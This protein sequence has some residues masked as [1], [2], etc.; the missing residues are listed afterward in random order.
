[1]SDEAPY[2]APRETL[3]P[4]LDLVSA[5]Y[6]LIQAWKKT[7]AYIR[8]HNW[9]ADTLAL[10]AA[11]VDLPRFLDGVRQSLGVAEAWA[12]RPLRAV[13]APKSQEWS[14]EAKSQ[15]WRP[16]SKNVRDAKLRPLAHVEL[17]EQ[18]AATAFLLCLADRVEEL[19]GDPEGKI[20]AR[21]GLPGAISYGNRLSCGIADGRLKHRWGSTKLYRSYFSD[22]R[23]FLA[24]PELVAQGFAGESC[25]V[26]QS[27]LRQFYDRV[28]P[29][30]MGRALDG[31]VQPGDDPSFFSALRNLLD[32][33]WDAKD[34]SFVEDY[35]LVNQIPDFASRVVL[36]QGLVA[37]GF[38]A[39]VV[40]LKFDD[41][42]RRSFGSEIAAGVV[43][44]DACRYVDDIRLVL[45]SE[46]KLDLGRLQLQVI[47]WLQSILD[48]S[49]SGLQVAGPEKTTLGYF[50]GEERPITHH[51]SRMERIQRAISGGFDALEGVEI[52]ASIDGLLKA[53]KRFSK[54]RTEGDGW[55]LSPVPDVRDETVARFAAG[56]FRSTY[57]SLRPLLDPDTAVFDRVALLNDVP[58]LSRGARKTRGDLDDD[59]KTF[60]LGLI[61]NWVHDPSN[62]RLLRIGLDLWP[63]VD[64]LDRVLQ[65]LRQYTIPGGRRKAPRLVAW[66]CVAELFRAAAT[67]TGFTDSREKLPDELDLDLY[68]RKLADEGALLMALPA[69]SVPWYVRQQVLLFCAAYHPPSST[70]LRSS[71]NLETKRYRELLLFM[72]GAK[73]P[74][75]ESEKA[76]A[77]MLVRRAFRDREGALNIVAGQLT[78]RMLHHIGESD[79][80]FALELI[81][82]LPH[83]PLGLSAQLRHDLGLTG[84]PETGTWSRLVE[85]TRETPNLLRKERML[86]R[87]AELWIEL[88]TKGQAPEVVAPVDVRVR[89][90]ESDDLADIEATSPRIGR[91]ESIYAPPEW[92]QEPDR[93]RFRLGYLLRFILTGCVDF[94]DSVRAPSWKEHAPIYRQVAGHWQ[95]RKYGFYNGHG[96]FGDHTLP[97]SDWFERFLFALLAWPG[98]THSEATTFVSAGRVQTLAE[99]VL[100]I[101]MLA[102][103]KGRASGVEVLPIATPWPM[104]VPVSRPLRIAVVQT[105]IPDAG[106]FKREDLSLSDPIVRNKHRNHLAAAVAALRRLLDLRATHRGT[107]GQVDLVILPELSV[108]P[109]D[110]ATHLMPF[111]RSH[112][113]IV[114]AGLTYHSP[115]VGAPL[116]NSAV[117]LIPT[118]HPK[119]G[120]QIVR[121]EQCKLHLAEQ[122]KA[123]NVPDPVVAGIRPCQWVVDYPWEAG[124]SAPLRLTASVC[125]DATDL[126]LAADMRERSDVFIVPALNRDV[127]TFDQM[128]LALHYHMYQYVVVA[129]N[130]SF[131]GSNSY[132]PFKEP[133]VR[134]VFHLHGQ[135]QATIAFLEIE[136]IHSLLNRG[137]DSSLPSVDGTPQA[138]RRHWKY[139]PAGW[140]GRHE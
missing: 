126:Q 85:V 140:A 5:D 129:N 28:S 34:R 3:S 83:L 38:F 105:V 125:Y 74:M 130:G 39:N 6:V 44:R 48:G 61:E 21:L 112:R 108:H 81:E 65:L 114:L 137:I 69:P 60:A 49:V 110:V 36:P 111:V 122:E 93:W 120:L 14:V 15:A 51:S 7:S 35:A 134:Q 107:Q 131:G 26:V 27:D 46:T 63:A 90:D 78:P 96:T 100:R 123:F 106:A 94:T 16:T 12:N 75:L 33:Q 104:R 99:V 86:L 70:V 102:R 18:V 136:D 17:R 109:D 13:P 116:I 50:R 118:W 132:A 62:V 43:L 11:A 84:Q 135:P 101:K 37:S 58:G 77:A 25:I 10:D 57:R 22:Y 2:E 98:T 71:R 66:Y 24:R 55:A 128:A 52:L 76:T 29:S 82:A 9:F 56:R 32:W 1:M 117:W 103:L 133:H 127:N 97:I 41:E 87:F 53:Q 121:R 91:D 67:E 80:A 64:V 139:P 95:R 8:A 119:G 4:Q 92:C 73:T 113:T 23:T 20:T 30:S 47:E 72:M 124:G 88:E 138:D 31:L 42:L 59:A 115:T 45:T 19:Q 40:L 54:S 89:F 79:P 68:R